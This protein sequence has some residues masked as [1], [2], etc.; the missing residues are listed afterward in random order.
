MLPKD[1]KN[2]LRWT[3]KIINDEVIKKL[4]TDIKLLQYINQRHIRYVGTI[5]KTEQPNESNYG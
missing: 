1:R 4:D 2:K 5:K 3:N